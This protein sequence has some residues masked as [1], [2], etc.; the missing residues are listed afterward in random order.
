ML[1]ADWLVST[2][3]YFCPP[4]SMVK[5]GMESVY[6]LYLANHQESIVGHMGVV[7]TSTGKD[8]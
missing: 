4:V 1:P 2:S 3:R 6:T 5:D 7:Y 8:A